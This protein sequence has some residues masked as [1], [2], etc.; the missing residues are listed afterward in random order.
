MIPVNG[1]AKLPAGPWSEYYVVGAGKTGMDATLFLLKRQVPAD[2]IN[3]VLPNDCWF[4][5]RETLCVPG[6]FTG[7]L[8]KVFNDDSL[9]DVTSHMHALEKEGLLS[10]FSSDI[11]P[12]RF[13]GAVVASGEVERMRSVN[14]VRTGRIERIEKDRI[15]FVNGETRPASAR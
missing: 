4:L 1:L 5:D 7:K 14:I 12:T 15:V 13:R 10:R 2:K 3:M 9:T 11:E 6:N 8:M